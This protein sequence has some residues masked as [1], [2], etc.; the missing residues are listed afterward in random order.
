MTSAFNGHSV[1]HNVLDLF[2][3]PDLLA[4]DCEGHGPMSNVV[5]IGA[6][7]P[8][9]FA[10]RQVSVSSTHFSDMVLVLTHLLFHECAQ[11]CSQ[12]TRELSLEE[13]VTVKAK[14][15]MAVILIR[16]MQEILGSN[17]TTT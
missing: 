15:D 5:F 7:D 6:L 3:V 11:G 10:R 9:L 16:E 1:E 17:K 12:I 2:A 13:R 8:A 14:L 4:L